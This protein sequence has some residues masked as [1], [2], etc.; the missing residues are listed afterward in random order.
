MT[1]PLPRMTIEGEFGQRGRP[2]E[3]PARGV[4]SI[5][6]GRGMTIHAVA[7]SSD[8][9]D[10]QSDEGGSQP[11]LLL[12]FPVDL[13]APRYDIH[14]VSFETASRWFE[15]W[16]YLGDA[17]PA[18]TYWG[19]FAPDLGAVVSIGLP[20]NV[21]GIAGRVGLSDIPGNVEINRVAVHPEMPSTT[22]R[23]MWLALRMAHNDAGWAW[24]FSYADTGQGHH[25]GIYQALGAVYVGLTATSH[26]WVHDNGTT[27][28][29]RT[30]VSIFGSQATDAMRQRGYTKVAEMGSRKHTYVLPV[31]PRAAEIRQRLVPL[32]LPYPKR[33]TA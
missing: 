29:P 7:A 33:E 31:G 19:V 26:R 20:N 15:R 22:S 18:S 12:H 11:T 13:S 17:P 10:F 28:H 23:V 27:L 8:A 1:K 25:G 30:A 4:P 24:A 3:E 21:H 16:H 9:A 32:A 6:A 14:P 5:F 2:F